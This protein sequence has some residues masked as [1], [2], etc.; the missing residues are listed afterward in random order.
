MLRKRSSSSTASPLHESDAPHA[1]LPMIAVTA[2]P[3]SPPVFL[4]KE[5]QKGDEDEDEQHEGAQENQEATPQ[6]DDGQLLSIPASAL[7]SRRMTAVRTAALDADSRA[8]S[9]AAISDQSIVPDAEDMAI[10]MSRTRK[11]ARAS[12]QCLICFEDIPCNADSEADATD[13][14]ADDA[15]ADGNS[16]GEQQ[17]DKE[18]WTCHSGCVVCKGCLT[19]FLRHKIYDNGFYN[20]QCPGYCQETLAYSD[21]AHANVDSGIKQQVKVGLALASNPDL[22]LYVTRP[23][24]SRLMCQPHARTHRERER[25]THTHTQAHSHT[26]PHTATHTH[27]PS[28]SNSPLPPFFF[29]LPSSFP[30]PQTASMQVPPM[31]RADRQQDKPSQPAVHTLQHLLLLLSQPRAPGA[32]VRAKDTWAE[33]ARGRPA[34]AVAKHPQ[35]QQVQAPDPKE[36]RL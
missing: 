24:A 35:M 23:T 10:I 18:Y 12:V 33:A 34:V 15:T 16:L 30:L 4:D 3:P 8:I 28:C 5:E 29:F 7:P 17:E 31:Q 11:R 6:Q 22:I 27:P 14:A 25:E 2:P 9:P 26:Q 21:F 36:R 20:M 1:R 19:I 32:R 13:D